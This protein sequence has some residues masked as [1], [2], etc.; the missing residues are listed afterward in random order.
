ME[1]NTKA[2]LL[3]IRSSFFAVFCLSLLSFVSD[4]RAYTDQIVIELPNAAKTIYDIRVHSFIHHLYDEGK[5]TD[6]NTKEWLTSSFE[7]ERQNYIEQYLA[8]NYVVEN[9]LNFRPSQ[10]Q[11][12]TQVNRINSLF[13]S[14]ESRKK[15]L[16]SLDVTD[17]DIQQW[18]I[19]RLILE[20][21]LSH[22]MQDRVVVT[23]QKLTTHY[24]S[25]KAQKFNNKP[26]D[27]V[28]AK[29]QEDLSKTLLKEEFAKWIDEEKR[30]QKMILKAVSSS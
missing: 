17:V 25:W 11:I 18:I 28:A 27:Q 14:P 7:N 1:K 3:R 23:D 9:N 15:T 24:E 6:P 26:Y 13:G 16:N 29:V 4:S 22:D 2:G 20:N 12:T 8:Q 5:V 21:F 10:E 30:R 19:N